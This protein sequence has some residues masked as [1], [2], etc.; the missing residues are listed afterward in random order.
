MEID[1]SLEEERNVAAKAEAERRAAEAEAA[2]REA[3][4][5]QAQAEA[6]AAAAVEAA[7]AEAAAAARREREERREAAAAALPAELS[8][9]G[10]LLSIRCPDGSRCLS[11][12]CQHPT[13]L[14]PPCARPAPAPLRE[15]PLASSRRCVRRLEPDAPL[16]AAFLLAEAGWV[17]QPGTAPLP[18]AFKLAAQFPRRVFARDGA[19]AVS[20][21]AAGLGGA[22]EALLIELPSE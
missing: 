2:A 19:A 16:E 20:L 5:A 9:G 8:A 12:P 11:P 17:E 7:E 3:A 13:A 18:P 21:A 4:A 15:R 1:I 6:A 22:Q 14:H 10:V